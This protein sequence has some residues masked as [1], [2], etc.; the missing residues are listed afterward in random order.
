MIGSE[1]LGSSAHY[2]SRLSITINSWSGVTLGAIDLETYWT[3]KLFA[4]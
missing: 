1:S 2:R 4:I 3:V